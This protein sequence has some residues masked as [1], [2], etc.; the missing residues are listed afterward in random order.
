[1]TALGST[2]ATILLSRDVALAEGLTAFT[3]LVV[4]QFIVTWVSVR[5]PRFE[6]WVKGEP[7]LLFHNGS[8]L[9]DAMRRERITREEMLAAMRL[10]GHDGPAGVASVVLE[11]DGSM[12]V[13]GR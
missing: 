12:S 8:F 7:R 3:L 10:A 1:L 9:N 11:T 4:L 13:V 2:L 6:N 5:L